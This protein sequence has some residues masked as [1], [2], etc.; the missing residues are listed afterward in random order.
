VSVYFAIT[1]AKCVTENL[2][3]QQ[4]FRTWAASHL[5]STFLLTGVE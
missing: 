2:D 1:N 3:L 5:A 4:R